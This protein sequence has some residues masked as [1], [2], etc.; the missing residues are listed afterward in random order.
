MGMDEQIQII[1]VPIM[2]FEM[3]S[4]H[5]VRCG[6]QAILVD[7]GVPGSHEKVQRALEANGLTFANIA[8]IVVT[9]AH[10]DHAGGAAKLREL[11]GAPIVGHRGDLEHYRG[12][13]PLKMCPTGLF[14]K[15][16][17]KTGVPLKP[18]R[19]FEPDIVLDGRDS[20]SLADYGLPGEVVSTPGHTDGTL[21]V[22]MRSGEAL[23]GD[24]LSSGVLLGGILLRGRPKRPPYED[25]PQAVADELEKLLEQGHEQF[26]VGHGRTLPSKAV[27]KHVERLRAL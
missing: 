5:V 23:V 2:P 13:E 8:L 16:F 18:Y 17:L 9:H 25:D 11:T 27:R 12:R 15:L 10:L 3:L 20:L 19:A 22:T 24:L 1:Q 21:S 4:A 6:D 14:G 26:F 7:A